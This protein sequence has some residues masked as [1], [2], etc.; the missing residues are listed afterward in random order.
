MVAFP[1]RRTYVVS[2][3]LDPGVRGFTR[4]VRGQSDD[5]LRRL[6]LLAQE[7]EENECVDEAGRPA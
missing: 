1:G 3:D 4:C 5:E 7:P 6:S 2:I